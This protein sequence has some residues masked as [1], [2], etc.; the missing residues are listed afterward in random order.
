MYCL[1]I[2]EDLSKFDIIPEKIR[3]G[4]DSRTTV[5]LR[6]IPKA[7]TFERPLTLQ[8]LQPWG[9]RGAAVALRLGQ[10]ARGQV[11]S[12]VYTSII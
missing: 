10:P 7:Q 6:N 8:G 4:E 9:Y 1:F 5:M 12:I 3:S 2:F 11:T